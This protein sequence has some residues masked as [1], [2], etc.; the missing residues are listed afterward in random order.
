MSATRVRNDGWTAARQLAFLTVLARTRSVTAAARAAGMSRE[1]AYRLRKRDAGGLFAVAWA[2]C[3][4]PRVT[5]SR[6]EVDEGHRRAIALACIPLRRAP[7]RSRAAPS[8][9]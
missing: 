1:S 6:G 4:A 3:F 7:A 9:A 5:R 8:T 2:S